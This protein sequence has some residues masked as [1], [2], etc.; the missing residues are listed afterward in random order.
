MAT[1]LRC[2]NCKREA[3]IPDDR[4]PERH[5][6][7]WWKLEPLGPDVHGFGEAPPRSFHLCCP[8]C[9]EEFA[10]VLYRP[11]VVLHG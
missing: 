11:K 4:P 1:V 2:D 6:V 7:G 3:E 9:I 10:P 5:V 8:K